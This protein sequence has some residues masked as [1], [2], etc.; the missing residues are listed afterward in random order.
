MSALAKVFV[1]FNFVMAVFF[2]GASATL[3]LTR[4]DWREAYRTYKRESDLKIQE[5][6]Q[7]QQKL[8]GTNDDLTSQI[9]RCNAELDSISAQ[10]KKL[11]EDLASANKEITV[12]R[13]QVNQCQ[14]AQ[15]EQAKLLKAEVDRN[16]SLQQQL[17]QANASREEAIDQLTQANEQRNSI[18]LDLDK[19]QGELHAMR[20]SVSELDSEHEELQ[21]RYDYLKSRC[22]NVDPGIVP[23]PIDAKVVD[24]DSDAKLVVLSV[25]RDQKVAKGYRFTVF[26]GDSFVAKVEVIEVY[27]DLSGARILYTKDGASI[28][29]GDSASTSLN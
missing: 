8:S 23:P 19:A 22:P 20:V 2:F 28:E 4:V 1:V 29:Q 14:V 13:D 25:G 17:A 12:A 10:N 6:G 3:F 7:L 15:G 21:L 5:L 27:P 24:V 18:R 11:A 16:A 26:R 9:A